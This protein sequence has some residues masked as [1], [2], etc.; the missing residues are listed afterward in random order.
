MSSP[1]LFLMRKNGEVSHLHDKC[2]VQP[3]YEDIDY[4]QW[5][6]Y[7]GKFEKGQGFAGILFGVV[8]YYYIAHGT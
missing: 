4:C 8:D 6:A 5:Q 2:K 7:F 1:K 3:I